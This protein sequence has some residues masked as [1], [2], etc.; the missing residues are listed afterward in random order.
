[1]PNWQILIVNKYPD[2]TDK[3]ELLKK[4]RK[5]MRV[6]DSTLNQRVP[7]TVIKV[8]KRKYDKLYYRSYR[9]ENAEY[10]RQYNEYH[11][12]THYLQIR[13]KARKKVECECGCVGK[14]CSITY[15]INSKK[16]TK[17]INEKLISYIY[18]LYYH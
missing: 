6:L 15:H 3:K 17:L 4:H 14:R 8:G 18:T 7:G 16:H 11:R 2:I 12:Q 13:T 5:S 9:E 1:M 10:Y